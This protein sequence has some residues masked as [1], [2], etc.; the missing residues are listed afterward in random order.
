VDRPRPFA[1]GAYLA[2][3]SEDKPFVRE[4]AEALHRLGWTTWL[5]EA[6]LIVG[7][8]LRR[9]LDDGLRSSRFGVVVLSHQFF[10]KRWPQDELD[11]VFGLD[12]D[13]EPRLLP[14]W[15]NLDEA[16]VRN[17]SP[18][19][20]SRFAVVSNGDANRAAETLAQ[21]MSRISGTTPSWA[22]RVRASTADGLVWV[23]QPEFAP[24]SLTY[25]D[26]HFV[27]FW[28]GRGEPWR[29]ESLDGPEPIL[30]SRLFD[31]FPR[32]EGKVVGVFGQQ[33]AQQLLGTVPSDGASLHEYV[34]QLKT[35]EPGYHHHLLYVRLAEWA[36]EPHLVD[37]PT[38][39]DDHLA[40]VVGVPVA[41]GAMTGTGGVTF[42]GLYMVAARLHYTPKL[43]ETGG[44]ADFA[45]I[46][47]GR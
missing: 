20:A 3:A 27:E 30:L 35:N 32:Y 26:D 25:L 42:N 39:P 22:D 44:P 7:R 47:R 46:P 13:E 19:I 31:E 29:D 45:D 23:R 9:Q 11:A 14:V 43:E 36:P 38:A 6:E 17:Y 37:V 28:R 41:R 4:L 16:D 5:D 1:Y 18:I 15:L 24:A 33:V 2:H 40:L 21:S 8:S 12:S 34:V 10:A